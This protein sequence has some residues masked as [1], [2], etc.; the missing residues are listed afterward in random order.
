M[1]RKLFLG[2]ILLFLLFNNNITAQISGALEICRNQTI[3][4]YY[5]VSGFAEGESVTWTITGGSGVGVKN[6]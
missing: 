5:S 1:S 2:I 4:Y 3:K 6:E